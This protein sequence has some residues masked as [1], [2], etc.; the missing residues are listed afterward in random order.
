MNSSFIS[1]RPVPGWT[2]LRFLL[3][4]MP[5]FLTVC[6][7]AVVRLPGTSLHLAA[8][9]PRHLLAASFALL[10]AVACAWLDSFLAPASHRIAGVS[11]RRRAAWTGRVALIQILILPVVF[12]IFVALAESNGI[13]V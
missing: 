1:G 5:G 9:G 8:S 3:W 6:L 2:F 10:L 11:P 4:L 7:L 12:L 13:R